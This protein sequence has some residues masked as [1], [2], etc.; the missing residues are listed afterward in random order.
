MGQAQWSG[1]KSGVQVRLRYHSPSAL[2]VHCCCHRLQ[3]A[4]VQA[5]SEHNEVKRVLVTLLTVWKTFHYS[6]KKAEKLVEVQ[7]VLNAPELK[8]QKP[9]ETRWLARERCVRA[10]R[11]SLPALVVT[12]EHIY[13]ESGDAEAYGIAKLLCTYKFV[14]CLYMLCDVLHTVA[15]LQGSL[16]SKVLD[17]ALIP[18]MVQTTVA[19]LVELKESPLSSTWFKD[20]TAVFSDVAAFG[21]RNITIS[22]DEKQSF[23]S[24]IYCPYIQ[25]V[26]NHIT[27]RMDSSDIYS[28]FSIFDP[29]HLPKNDS[30]SSYGNDKLHTLTNFYGSPQQ[31][32][33]DG[34]TKLSTP[35]VVA[36]ETE[37]EWKIFRRI[38]STNF[39]S[40]SLSEVLTSITTNETLKAGFPNLERLAALAMVL[41]V[42][43]ATVERSFSNM[44]LVKTRLRSR[45]GEDTLDQALRVCIEGPAKKE[46]EVIINHWKEQKHRKLIL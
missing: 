30:L 14:A 5:A 19:R 46:L 23:T 24:K 27:S 36:E 38:L 34:Q 2:F 15:K 12:F 18:V 9:S 3:L 42:T 40:S 28:A 31:I 11:L 39:S 44:K 13:E 43:T 35:D 21:N 37:A 8:M 26:I 17:L 25:S 32:T 41:P 6:P 1:K 29:S 10:V 16:Q 4:A 22:E 33:F 20:H 7:A 45:L